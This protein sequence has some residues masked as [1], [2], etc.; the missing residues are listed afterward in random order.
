[1]SMNDILRS[2]YSRTWRDHQ[3]FGA[4]HDAMAFMHSWS[5][6]GSG[7]KNDFRNHPPLKHE[8]QK[9]SGTGRADEALSAVL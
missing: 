2:L 6:T 4:G 3:S 8:G 5:V 9:S 1:M 7:C